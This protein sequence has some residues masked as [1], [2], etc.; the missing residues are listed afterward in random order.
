MLE[1]V[2]QLTRH[3][4]TPSAYFGLHFAS[5]SSRFS[6]CCSSPYF[7]KSAGRETL[8][9]KTLF[10]DKLNP[11][12]LGV[13]PGSVNEM[14]REITR[15]LP[16]SKSSLVFQIPVQHGRRFRPCRIALRVNAVF[17]FAGDDTLCHSPDYR[18]PCPAGNA[19]TI[20]EHQL[21]RRQCR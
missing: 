3:D 2:G 7:A 16:I 4:L 17:R 11:A 8:R 19:V 20:G 6:F 10:F 12:I 13:L 18:V 1:N 21:A 14:W 5:N 15:Q 9:R